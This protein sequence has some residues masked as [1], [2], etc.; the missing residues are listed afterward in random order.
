[1]MRGG[2]LVGAKRILIVEDMPDWRDQLQA[3]LRR[4]GYDI[5]TV[6]SYGE[7]LAELRRNPYDL[8]LVDL[9]LSPADESNRDGMD[10]LRDLARA[11]VPAVVVT[12]Y[13]GVELARKAIDQYHAFDF[14]EKQTLDLNRLREVIKAAFK[15]AKEKEKRL[16]ELRDKVFRGEIITY[17][18]PEDAVNPLLREE[19]E[20][21]DQ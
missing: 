5:T 10:L 20:D 9:R 1:M 19:K 14:M 12:G 8:T 16:Q 15:K 3:T 21:Y 11:N 13:G 4:D 17:D 7:A 2:E 18:V 6:P